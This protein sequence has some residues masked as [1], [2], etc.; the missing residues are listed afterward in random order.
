VDRVLTRRE[1][2]RAL[3][4]RQHLIQ[5]VSAPALAEIEHLVGMQAQT[6]RAPYVALW[7]RL[8]GFDPAELE[9]LVEARQVVRAAGMLPTTIHLVSADDALTMRPVLQGVASR[10]F[11]TGSPFG[12]RLEGVD[13]GEVIA[14]GHRLLDEQPMSTAELGRRLHVQWPDRDA[15]S[16]AMAFRYLV[17][18]VQVPP[19]GLW[20]RSFPPVFTTMEAWLGRPLATESAPDAFVLRYLA[21]FGPASLA[22]VATWSWLTGLRPVI[23]RLR[24][25]LRTFRDEQSR[26]LFDVPDGALP[27]PEV[28]AP[29][30]FLPEYDNLLLSHKDRTRVTARDRKIP[31]PAGDGGRMGTFLVDGFTAGTWRFSR[32]RDRAILAIEP[33]EPLGATEQAA[34]EGEGGRLLA[35]LAPGAQ[36]EVQLRPPT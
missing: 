6:P 15:Q 18:V 14:A 28:P 1:L 26:E 21:A 36:S 29:P 11:L 2:N 19:R 22:D 25:S 17:P 13:V 31:W 9:A 4:A 27:D 33:W 23:E 32:E 34:L 3:L 16:L 5:R 8:H 7:S 35:F 20:H 30:R 12:R 24:P 10:G